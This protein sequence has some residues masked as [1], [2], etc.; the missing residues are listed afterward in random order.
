M[1]TMA[2]F[3]VLS[4]ELLLAIG[5]SVGGGRR[6]RRW[7]QRRLAAEA[8]LAQS[9][10]SDIE[11][12]ALRDLPLRTA[13]QVLTA[14]DVEVVLG[15]HPPRLTAARQR[16]RA[17]ARCIA[18]VARRLERAGWHVA[19]E[20]EVGGG[21]WLGF[22]DVLA[23][24]P[25][26]HVLLV[27]EVKTEVR[28]VGEIDRQMSSYERS[29][30]AAALGRGWRPRAATG[31]L[32]LLSTDESDRRLLENR[33]YF[34]RAFRVRARALRDL[35]DRPSTPPPRGARGLGMIDPGSRRYDW[36]MPTWLDGRR[37]LARY[38][39]R[40]DY[41]GRGRSVGRPKAVASGKRTTEGPSGA[42]L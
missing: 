4:R 33:G 40:A 39:D 41:I 15:L 26:E 18:F 29:A 25:D 31:I 19:T 16:D 34:D 9:M 37:T 20:I 5:A 27:I 11:H 32:L 28:D 21:R 8:N 14:L 38:H 1:G 12:A 17:H 13:I 35:V 36:I 42:D 24:H 30:W 2:R 10:I 22:V 6:A 3:E 23:Y 7:P